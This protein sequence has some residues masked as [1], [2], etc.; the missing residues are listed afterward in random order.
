MGCVS[1][2]DAPA[3][4]GEVTA[5]DAADAGQADAAD[6]GQ[7]RRRGLRQ[8]AT[9]MMRSMAVIVAVVLG[10]VLLVPRPNE[11]VQPA[12]DVAS[13]AAAA[14]RR[15]GFPVAVPA[16]LP[17]SWTPTN[18]RVQDGTDGVLSWRV[19]Y[20]TD[21]QQPAG[22]IQARNPTREWE[23]TQVIDGAE[24][25]SAVIDGRTWVLRS[26]PDRGI[27]NYVFRQPDLTT[28]VTGRAGAAE[29]TQLARSLS[30]PG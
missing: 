6:A 16:G 18:A 10:L 19:G 5:A 21:Q 4:P 25:G 9:D 20:V 1:S 7:R 28:I 27:T 17:A 12:I 29:L 22:I 8:S 26:R 24:R 15:L 11:I 3:D 13:A 14:T 2:A 30:L 23:D